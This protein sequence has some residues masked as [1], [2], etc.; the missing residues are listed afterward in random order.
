MAAAGIR[1]AVVGCPRTRRGYRRGLPE[2]GRNAVIAPRAGTI[3]LGAP[4][5]R[6]AAN[7]APAATEGTLRG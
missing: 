7:A 1:E 6:R 4:I 3:G 2:A 5:G